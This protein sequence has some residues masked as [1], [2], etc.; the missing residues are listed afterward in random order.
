MPVETQCCD[1]T[2]STNMSASCYLSILARE[3]MILETTA[4]C[5]LCMELVAPGK[6]IQLEK[7]SEEGEAGCSLMQDDVISLHLG[8]SSS[9]RGGRKSRPL[10]ARAFQIF[11]TSSPKRLTSSELQSL[12]RSGRMKKSLHCQGGVRL[13]LSRSRASAV[14]CCQAT[15][16]CMPCRETTLTCSN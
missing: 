14:F 8:C 16:W 10:N 6:L 12:Y 2:Y 4:A 1:S 7:T 9:R 11:R 5:S 15:N 13:W 3:V